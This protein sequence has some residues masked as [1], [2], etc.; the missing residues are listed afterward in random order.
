MI[1]NNFLKKYIKNEVDLLSWKEHFKLALFTEA[2][3]PHPSLD[4]TYSEILLNTNAEVKGKNYEAGGLEVEFQEAVELSDD[5]NL[6]FKCKGAVWKKAT[7]SDVRYAVIYREALEGEVNSDI[8]V[9]YYDLGDPRSVENGTFTISWGGSYALIISLGVLGDTV[10]AGGTDVDSH[11][12]TSSGNPVQNKTLT[13]T[14]GAVG[15]R[16]EDD[17]TGDIES[18]PD[19]AETI[20]DKLDVL[21]EFTVSEIDAIFNKDTTIAITFIPVGFESESF[22]EKHTV[23]QDVTLPDVTSIENH[24]LQGWYKSS[25]C[26]SYYYVGAAGDT[27]DINRS[28]I[29]Y[30]KM[31]EVE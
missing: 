19:T 18:I 22:I 20:E 26:T 1:Y 7:F 30:G 3:S 11:L 9:A 16:F 2:Y 31:E 28:L 27:V 4:K 25:K 5:N 10:Y 6:Y 17:D 21:R 15:V 23:N 14:I 12:S 24:K 29:L 8:L 13:E